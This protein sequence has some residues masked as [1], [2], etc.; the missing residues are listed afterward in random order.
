MSPIRVDIN[1]HIATVVL[2]FPLSMPC[3]RPNTPS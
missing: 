2:D 3:P 1:E